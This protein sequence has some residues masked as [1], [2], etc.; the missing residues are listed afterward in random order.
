[1]K[2]WNRSKRARTESWVKVTVTG[3]MPRDLKTMLQQHNS[4]N[5]FFIEPGSIYTRYFNRSTV[6]YYKNNIPVDVWFEK[7]EDAVFF[8]LLLT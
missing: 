1:M 2:Y 4:E 6:V 7:E 3:H 8:T 5:R